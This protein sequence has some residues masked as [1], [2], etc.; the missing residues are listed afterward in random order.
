MFEGHSLSPTWGPIHLEFR[1]KKE[2]LILKNEIDA[3]KGNDAEIKKKG[4]YMFFT[5]H[6]RPTYFDITVSNMLCLSE[7]KNTS[8]SHAGSAAADA[9]AKKHLHDAGGA[10][11]LLSLETLCPQDHND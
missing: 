5:N 8:A 10:F 6:C 9:E 4:K 11:I 1:V 7:K 3:L 2:I